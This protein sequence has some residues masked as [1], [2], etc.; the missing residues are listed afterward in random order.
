M[1][2][3]RKLA[4][5]ALLWA[6]WQIVQ[7]ARKRAY[8][9]G[10]LQGREDVIGIVEAERRKREQIAGIMVELSP[11]S[12]LYDEDGFPLDMDEATREQISAAIDADM[13]EDERLYQQAET[14]WQKRY[15]EAV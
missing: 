2:I 6:I 10:R 5:A 7:D 8:K 15:M 13:E 14:V 3:I 9:Q 11:Y 1:S 12:D 4:F